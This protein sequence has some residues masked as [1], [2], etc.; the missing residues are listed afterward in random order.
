V[1][2]K[3]PSLSILGIPPRDRPLENIAAPSKTRDK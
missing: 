3:R 1:T 2:P